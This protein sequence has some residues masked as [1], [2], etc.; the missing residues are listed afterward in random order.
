MLGLGCGVPET[1]ETWR[2]Y[3]YD[4][5]R[6]VSRHAEAV[7]A[8]VTLLREGRATYAGEFVHLDGAEVVPAGPRPGGP[9]VWIAGKGE[10]TMAIA[11]RFGDA[12]NVNRMLADAADAA[13]IV[14]QA[15]GACVAPGRDPAS[16]PVTGLARVALRPD[17][18]AEARSGWIGG[19][20][21]DVAATLRGIARAGVGHV[22]LFVGADDD[23][24]PFPALT[25]ATLDRLA[26]VLEALSAA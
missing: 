7:E 16:L 9:P 12:V 10:R 19:S 24:S 2:A 11:A 5:V 14:D 20:P 3:G 23:P 18:T 26:P 25:R 6:H 13:A 17:G 22:T 1:D 21:E 15:A 4:P 8:I